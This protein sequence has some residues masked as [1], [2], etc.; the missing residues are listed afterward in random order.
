MILNI[1]SYLELWDRYKNK[2]FSCYSNYY[3]YWDNLKVVICGKYTNLNKTTK[4]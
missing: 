2:Y 4:N 3:K 1:S